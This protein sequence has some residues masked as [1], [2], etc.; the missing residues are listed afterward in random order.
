MI[1]LLSYNFYQLFKETEEGK[2]YIG[3]NYV[4][5]HKKGLYIVK[6]IRTVISIDNYF[7][8]FYMDELLDLYLK[9]S[10]RKENKSKDY[11]SFSFKMLL[12]NFAN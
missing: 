6:G 2:E 8:V 11:L 5:E 9:L 3:K 1:S 10:E 12:F 7:T 4:V